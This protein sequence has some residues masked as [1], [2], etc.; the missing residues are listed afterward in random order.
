MLGITIL[1]VTTFLCLALPG[2]LQPP[3]IHLADRL[4]LWS[5][6]LWVF[7]IS[8][9]AHPALILFGEAEL[10]LKV[11]QMVSCRNSC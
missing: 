9:A 4:H 2:L 3:A 6:P 11:N 5:V 1:L 7:F 10:K 8:R